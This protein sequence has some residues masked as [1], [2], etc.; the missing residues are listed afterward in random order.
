MNI[1]TFEHGIGSFQCQLPLQTHCDLWFANLIVCEIWIVLINR[2]VAQQFDCFHAKTNPFHC[3]FDAVSTCF[4]NDRRKLL[5]FNKPFKSYQWKFFVFC[6]LKIWTLEQ[7]TFSLK[8]FLLKNSTITNKQLLME[9]FPKTFHI[10]GRIISAVALFI[11]MAS[12]DPVHCVIVTINYNVLI[13]KIE[14]AL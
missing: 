4:A 14:E 12:Y 9:I 1:W 13:V 3:I 8:L 10:F 6:E 7:P 11:S 5:P 2:I